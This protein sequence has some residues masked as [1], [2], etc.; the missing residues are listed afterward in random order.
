[1]KLS[2]L[3]VLAALTLTV[4]ACSIMKKSKK[5]VTASAPAQPSTPVIPG[6]APAVKPKDG[7]FAPGNDELIAIQANH[8]DVTLQTLTDGYE[9]Y[10]GVCTNCHG[11]MSIYER[12]ETA[13]PAIID[14]MAPR[15]K[16]T[17]AQ[18]DALYKYVM[19]IKATQHK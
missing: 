18:K 8:K 1:M 4:T 5:S 6:I 11:T 17:S 2:K 14:D 19:A 9:I 13:W 10:T 12:P 7:V 15:A 3:F 16:I